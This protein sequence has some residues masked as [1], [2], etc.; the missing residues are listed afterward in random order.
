MVLVLQ[1]EDVRPHSESGPYADFEAPGYWWTETPCFSEGFGRV[2]LEGGYGFIDNTGKVVLQ[3]YQNAKGFSEGL[4]AVADAEVGGRWGYIDKSG[5][6]VIPYQFQYAKNFSEG[7]AR[8]MVKERWGYIDKSGHL[9]IPA[10]Y[11]LATDFS[12]GRA[13]VRTPGD[14]G[15][16]YAWI[17]QKGQRDNSYSS[18]PPWASKYDWVRPFSEG[19][20]AVGYRGHGG[21]VDESGKLVLDL[22]P[23]LGDSFHEG[24]A[25]ALKGKHWGYINRQGKFIIKPQFK[26]AQGFSEGR[27][28]VRM[29][30]KWGYVDKAGQLVIPPQFNLPGQ[31]SDGV[32]CVQINESMSSYAY[33]DKTSRIIW[34]GPFF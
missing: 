2:K 4:A 17:D 25:S 27:A 15:F 1:V 8:V 23:V 16:V 22:G 12:G 11:D 5:A 18:R 31:F 6:L 33:I 26:M 30:N 34:R 32:A 21:F 29:G 28:A 20:A 14:Y 3:L 10:V 19:L 9:V 13:E 24:L 7:L